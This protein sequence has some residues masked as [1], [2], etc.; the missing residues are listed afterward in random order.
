MHLATYS[1][2]DAGRM[3]AHYERA[4]G[5]RDHIDRDGVVYNLGPEPGSDIHERFR[6]LTEGLEI[7]AKTRPLADFVVTTPRSY[8]GDAE[9]LF[10]AVYDS[11]AARVG[12]EHVVAAYVHL[13]EPGARPHMHFAFV[14]VVETP[15][16]TNDKTQPLLWTERD[17]KKNPAHKAGTQKRDSKGTPRYKRVPLLGEDGRP[18]VRRTAAASKIFSKED[19]RELHPQV[20]A[21]VCAALGIDRVGLVLDEDDDARKLSALDHSEYE[22]TTATI[23][24]A[25]ERM[26]ELR[27]EILRQV[28]EIGAGQQ[29]L[30]CLRQREDALQS[31]KEPVA[32]SVRTL[33]ET[34]GDGARERELAAE[35]EQL[36]AGIADLERQVRDARERA[37]AL[38]AGNDRL[39]D[40][41]G[42]AR[43]RNR[44]LADRFGALELRVRSAIGRLSEIPNTLS[45]WALG[46]A[47][48]LGKRVYDPN[49][50]ERA[51]SRATEAARSQPR[52][53]FR[54]RDHGRGFSR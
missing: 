31:A 35:K 13:D 7:G 41:L 51:M 45:R 16:M 34:R 32:K 42:R 54:G 30:E 29:R 22:R 8:E 14:P 44:E 23:A 36:G 19:M 26:E 49:S 46:I 33:V 48:E 15:V 40:E 9:S 24:R 52:Q 10:K 20:E 38:A 6:T 1:K 18:V 25:R 17:E 11:L 5:E 47:H 50:L 3:L 37:G 12:E 43:G 21:E 28:E 27:A 2:A 53:P 4:I 39:R